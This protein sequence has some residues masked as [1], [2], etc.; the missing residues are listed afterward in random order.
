MSL[1][2]IDY[3]GAFFNWHMRT[4]YFIQ[5]RLD[6][7]VHIFRRKLFYLLFLGLARNMLA[8]LKF[9]PSSGQLFRSLKA[10]IC[11]RLIVEIDQVPLVAYFRLWKQINYH[12][13]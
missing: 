1:L 7:S 8:F 11:F 9:V 10:C 13:H 12:K 4:L 5:G 6:K 2:D 3:G